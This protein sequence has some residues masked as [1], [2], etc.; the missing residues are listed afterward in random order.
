MD[1]ARSLIL[2]QEALTKALQLWGPLHIDRAVVFIY[3]LQFECTS[4]DGDPLFV[5]E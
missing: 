5:G 3:K 4:C 2:F 1:G